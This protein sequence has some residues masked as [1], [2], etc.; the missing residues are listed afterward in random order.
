M[1]ERGLVI[2]T[3][4]TVIGKGVKV[5]AKGN[6]LIAPYN[7]L[8]DKIYRLEKYIHSTEAEIYDNFGTRYTFAEL[9]AEKKRKETGSF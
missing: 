2:I 4:R 7:E 1:S 9:V 6:A 3:R 5:Y 8:V